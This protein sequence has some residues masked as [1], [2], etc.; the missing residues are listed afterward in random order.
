MTTCIDAT[1][2]SRP[3]TIIA[4]EL[5]G[6]TLVRQ[7]SDGSILR[8]MIVETEAYAPDDPA[9]HAYRG[10]T[11]RNQVM[12]GVAGKAYVYL[13]YGMYYCLNVVTDRDGV[14]SAVLLRALELDQVPNWVNHKEKLKPHRIAAGPGKLCRALN[15][16][17]TLNATPLE[18][19]QPLWLEHRHPEFQQQLDQGHLTLIQTTRIGLTKGV[20]LPWRWYLFHSPA[21]SKKG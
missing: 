2:L 9:M 1:W 15:I 21:V 5:I 20:D 8:G 17:S 7:M 18:F 11:T 16:D 13:I 19:G 6:C 10:R 12:F 14:A 3:S 4:P